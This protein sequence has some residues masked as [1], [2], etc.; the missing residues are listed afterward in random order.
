MSEGQAWPPYELGI[1]TARVR[2][3]SP[4]PQVTEHSVQEVQLPI[5][6]S[7]GHNGLFS[8]EILWFVSGQAAPV[9]SAG[10]VTALARVVKPPVPHV[11]VHTDHS[12]QA[13]TL[14]STLHAL[15]RQLKGPSV[16]VGH[17]TPPDSAGTDALRVRVYDPV[18]QVAEHC[19]QA[20]HEFMT[21]STGH[22]S[23]LQA[24]DSLKVPLHVPVPIAGEMTLRARECMLDA[25]HVAGQSVHPCHSPSVQS[26]GQASVAHVAS[27]VVDGHAVPWKPLS[28]PS[29]VG[30]VMERFLKTVPAPPHVTLHCDHSAQSP[31][32]QSEQESGSSWEQKMDSEIPGHARPPFSA[33][34]STYLSRLTSAVAQLVP[35]Q[36][37]HS[38]QNATTQSVGHIPAFVHALI[39]SSEFTSHAMPLPADGEVITRVRFIVAPALWH[40]AEHSEKSDHE[41]YSQSDGQ[42]PA[43]HEASSVSAGQALG[44]PV[45]TELPAGS[46]NTFRDRVVVPT[47]HDSEQTAHDS[48]ESTTHSTGQSL[49]LHVAD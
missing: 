20:P 34:S 12:C 38:C 4:A 47:P 45:S 3:V 33:T 30:T 43:V 39:S 28:L 21:Q 36:V 14:Q 25:P 31:T 44:S 2:L 35:V 18:P 32:S 7:I 37:P 5:V 6:Q 40:V 29:P 24:L 42:V 9:P 10:T 41:L 23:E 46:V 19:P 8:Q 1:C 15:M 48:Q 13:S 16:A 22:D 26:S 49:I 17:A 27:S 11:W